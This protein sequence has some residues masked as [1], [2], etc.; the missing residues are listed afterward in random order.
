MQASILD[1]EK[2]ESRK[3]R[4]MI[5]REEKIKERKERRIYRSKKGKKKNC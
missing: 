2:L 5:L 1:L 3:D 4:K